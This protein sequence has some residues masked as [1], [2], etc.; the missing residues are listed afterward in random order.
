M[1]QNLGKFSI[2]F[3]VGEAFSLVFFFVTRSFFLTTTQT[4]E[5]EPHYKVLYAGLTS[6]AALAIICLL[7]VVL[8]VISILI[9]KRKLPNR[10]IT[11]SVI[12]AVLFCLGIIGM[13]HTIMGDALWLGMD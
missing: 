2:G 8:G 11:A 1:A 7:P 9:V 3:V 6:E 13:F 4:P 10:T 5:S 12:L